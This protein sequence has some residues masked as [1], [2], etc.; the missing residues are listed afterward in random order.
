[1]P[2][3]LSIMFAVNWFGVTKKDP[4]G[5]GGDGAYGNWHWTDAACSLNNDPATCEAFPGAGQQRSIASKRRPLAGIYSSSGR[6]DESRRRVDLMLSTVRRP[7]DDGARLDAFSLQLDSVKFTSRHPEN[8]QSETW[9]IAYR[10]LRTFLERADAAGMNGAVELADDSTVYWHFGD[11]FGVTTQAERLAALTDDVVDMIE[12]G[13][14]H[15][16]ATRI[17]GKLLLSFYVDA[18]LISAAEWAKVLDDARV[19]SGKDFYA[20]ATTLDAQYF[21]AFDAISPWLNLDIWAS[22]KGASLHDRAVDYGKRMHGGLIAALAKYPGRVVFGSAT[23]GFDD[24]TMDWGA[25]RAREIPRD[26]EVLAGQLDALIAEKKSGADLRGLVFQTWDDWTEGSEFEPDVTEG[27]AKLVQLRQLI[28]AFHGE[29]LD[30]TGDDALDARWRSY[31]Q[32]RSCCFLDGSCGDSGPPTIDLKCPPPLA[33]GGVSDA[34]IDAK[35]DAPLDSPLDAPTT[36]GDSAALD[37]AA[38]I[39]HDAS[40]SGGCGCRLAT[41]S[42]FEGAGVAFV[43]VA[44]SL[45]RRRR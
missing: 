22:S 31:G 9:D 39:T 3:R 42:S 10:A 45:L 32:A 11:T 26:A 19:R 25:C 15:P 1:M 43:I 36:T 23:A 7:C 24:Y 5:D 41:R 34:T 33:D 16:S 20:L 27:T 13:A 40:S 37:D 14:A 21:Q 29:P 6:T 28:G 12:L 4:Q 38:P 18:A 35:S 8:K 44:L 17:D 2:S 30:K